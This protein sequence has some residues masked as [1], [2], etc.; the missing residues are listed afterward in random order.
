[1]HSFPRRHLHV[2]SRFH[3]IARFCADRFQIGIAGDERL[4]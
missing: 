4:S 2:F 1:L 3:V